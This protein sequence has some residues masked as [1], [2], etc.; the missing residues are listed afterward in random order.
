M[1]RPT[2]AIA[3]MSGFM[4]FPLETE[5]YSVFCNIAATKSHPEWWGEPRRHGR[6]V[7]FP[8]GPAR[9]I[10]LSLLLPQSGH[11]DADRCP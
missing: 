8:D 3:E 9:G 1:A 10:V 6:R 2:L 5:E 7:L 11:Y 4:T